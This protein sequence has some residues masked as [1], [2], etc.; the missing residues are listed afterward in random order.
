MQNRKLQLANIWSL[1]L[2]NLVSEQTTLFI[3]CPLKLTPF[4]EQEIRALGFTPISVSDAGVSI[5]GSIREAMAICLHSRIASRVLFLLKEFYIRTPMD[6]YKS[7]YSIPWEDIIPDDGYFSVVTS[8]DTRTITNTHFAGQK[9]KDAIVDR[10]RKHRSRR[11]D[12]GA[13]KDKTVL[14]LYWHDNKGAIYIDMA[15]TPLHRRGYRI[16]PW[17]APMRENLAAAVIAATKWAPYSMPFVNPMCGSG[18]LAIEAAMM[19]SDTAPGSLRKNFGFMHVFGYDKEF[20]RHLLLDAVNAKRTCERPYIFASD[21]HPGAVRIARDNARE[22]G[23]D[24]WIE[25][26]VKDVRNIT[27][28]EQNGIIIMN[29]EYGQRLGT[30]KTLEEEYKEI[31]DIFKKKCS[32]WTGYVFTGNLQAAKSIGLRTSKRIPFF[33]ADIEC[34]LLEF[35]LYQG[36]KE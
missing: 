19:A 33:N 17:Q 25:W 24:E 6:M 16:N 29:P 34:R 27:L 14:F 36:K 26:S 8:I 3:T 22:A 4:L 12:S 21:I 20:W 18:T 1:S 5:K 31:G 7:V 11:P 32:G 23:I 10:I 13:D 28:P 30:E 2:S 35:E 9:C 15:G